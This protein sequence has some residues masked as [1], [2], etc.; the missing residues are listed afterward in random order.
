MDAI[1][2]DSA[3]PLSISA[4]REASTLTITLQ[5]E[6]DISNV[7]ALD[8]AL[9]RELEDRPQELIVDVG[10][11][12]FMDSSGIAALLRARKQVGT[13]TLRSPSQIIRRVIVGAG[14]VDILRLEP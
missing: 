2:G 6:L 8:E 3:A 9:A 5:G 7:P 4:A 10:R 14:L 13:L 12:A 1:E 11:L